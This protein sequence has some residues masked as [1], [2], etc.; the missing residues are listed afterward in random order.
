MVVGRRDPTTE[1][2][3]QAKLKKD[4]TVLVA[5]DILFNLLEKRREL[6]KHTKMLKQYLCSH[7]NKNDTA[8]KLSL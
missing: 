4:V 5:A 7:E 6:F 8:D 1:P 2:G 3:L